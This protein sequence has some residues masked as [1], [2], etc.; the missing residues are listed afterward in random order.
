[1]SDKHITSETKNNR[2]FVTVV[3]LNTGKTVEASQSYGVIRNESEAKSEAI[4]KAV[5]KL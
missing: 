5:K 1:M 3:D 4:A 2:V